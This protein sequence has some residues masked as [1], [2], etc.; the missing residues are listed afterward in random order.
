[1]KRD[2]PDCGGR[3]A[4]TTTV[5]DV[6]W[7][8]LVLGL[9]AASVGL[10]SPVITYRYMS[11]MDHDRWVRERRA[12]AYV[13]VMTMCLLDHQAVADLPD[14]VADIGEYL[15]ARSPYQDPDGQ[16]TGQMI[17]AFGSPDMVNLMLRWAAIQHKLVKLG[18]KRDQV[19]PLLQ[20][21]EEVHWEMN[22]VVMREI[23][24]TRTAARSAR[25]AAA[26]WQDQA[27]RVPQVNSDEAPDGSTQ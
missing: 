15:R 24:G 6:D 5:T 12:E 27:D 19:S 26:G 16:E 4:A 9:A 3:R 8:S 1:M 18:A 10:L 2:G 22:K 23:Q 20:K 17:I 13:R 21:L 14:D 11:R 25:A 7:T